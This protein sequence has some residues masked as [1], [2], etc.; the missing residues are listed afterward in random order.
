MSQTVNPKCRAFCFTLN[1]YTDLEY[2]ALSSMDCRYLC[3]GK[4]V[5][6]S[7][8]PHLQGYVYYENP[9][10]FNAVKKSLGKRCHVE[11]SGGTPKQASDY[12]KK[13]GD[14]IE[15]GECPLQGNRSDIDVVRELIKEGNGMRNI[16]DVASSYQSIKCA[17]SILKYKE[18][19]R[20]F[21]TET[22]WVYGKSGSGKT[23][24]A[25][26]KHPHDEIHLQSAN[27]KW[28]EGYDSHPVVIIDEVDWDTS[29]SMLKLLCDRF[30]ARVEYKGGSRSFLAKTIYITSLSHP[31]DLFASH[32]EN[33]KEMLRRIDKIISLA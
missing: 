1:N 12:C 15:I 7:G 8:T 13:D 28:Y 6:E 2:T 29:Y 20:N 21:K 30:P 17:E 9:R 24:Y 19:K 33:G 5:G 3:I 27:T 4:E 22:I 11:A 16:V 10:S 26:D 32:P 18:I 31:A 14:F 23:R 25:Y